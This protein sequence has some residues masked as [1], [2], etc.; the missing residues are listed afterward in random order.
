MRYLRVHNCAAAEDTLSCCSVGRDLYRIGDDSAS[1]LDRGAGSY[2]FSVGT[3]CHQNRDR[4]QG[5]NETRHNFRTGCNRVLVHISGVGNQ[6]FGRP[7]AT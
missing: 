7:K 6:N 1:R 2:F 5:F 4:L 3:G